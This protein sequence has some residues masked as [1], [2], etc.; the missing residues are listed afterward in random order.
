MSLYC[1]HRDEGTQR[2]TFYSTPSSTQK[3]QLVSFH[4]DLPSHRSFPI[5]SP[6]LD[7]DRKVKSTSS[8]LAKLQLTK[9]DFDTLRRR[10]N[11]FILGSSRSPRSHRRHPLTEKL[12]LRQGLS[13]ITSHFFIHHKTDLKHFIPNWKNSF[14]VVRAYTVDV[15]AYI[16]SATQEYLC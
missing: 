16:L 14:L 10:E 13:T 5:S 4:L 7:L 3:T 1:T 9:E 12:H 6:D 2:I 8:S 15:C 11:R